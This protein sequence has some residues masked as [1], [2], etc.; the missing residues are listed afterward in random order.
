MVLQIFHFRTAISRTHP[1]QILA[2]KGHMEHLMKAQ[3]H[4]TERVYHKE[5]E[6]NG[7]FTT[8]H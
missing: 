8:K 2:P 6:S 4:N 5:Y 1:A 3:D 7:Y